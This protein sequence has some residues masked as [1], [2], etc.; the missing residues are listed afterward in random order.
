MA[1]PQKTLLD[2]PEWATFR[3]RFA[4]SLNDFSIAV[5][6]RLPTPQQE[7]LFHSVELSGS[8]TSVSSGHGCFGEGMEIPL[9]DGTIKRVEAISVGDRLLGLDGATPEVK[10]LA[11]GYEAMYRFT[12]A[13]GSSHTFNESHNIVL[14]D[15]GELITGTVRDFLCGIEQGDCCQFVDGEYQSLEIVSIESLGEGAYYG[16]ELDGN[17]L[18]FDRNGIVLSNTGKTGA[19]GVIVL[20]HLLCYPMS[21]TIVTAPRIAQVKNLAW[22]E[23]V[24][25]KRAM[26]ETQFSWLADEIVVESERIYI[27]GFKEGWY[28]I[29]KT[30]P[31]GNPENLA[32][33]HRNH[34]LWIVD[35]ASG[36]ED[37]HYAV[38]TGALTDSRN[39]MLLT[40]QPTRPSGF[41]YDTHHKLARKNGGVWT[42]LTFDSEKSLKPLGLV[43]PEFIA[44]K[45]LQYTETEYQIKVKGRFPDKTDG[46]LIGRSE[47]EKAFR[48]SC[49]KAEEEWGWMT[50]IDVGGGDYR[51][52]SV[53]LR[54][55]VIGDGDYGENARRIHIHSV[56]I[57][58][59]DMDEIQFSGAVFNYLIEQRLI[60]ETCMLD[61]GS[62]G[63]AV[64][65]ILEEKGT[66]AL[67]RVLWG[68][69]CWKTENKERFSNLRAQANAYA[70]RAVREGRLTFDS[71]I[72]GRI[73]NQILDEASRI[74]F[75]YDEKARYVIEKKEDMRK[76]GIPSPDIW[77]AVCFLFLEGAYYAVSYAD[78]AEGGGDIE[79]FNR[80]AD[81]YF[82]SIPD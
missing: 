18:F 45:R 42:A 54:A 71:S 47:I 33:E 35:E 43:S 48:E 77:D 36:V 25:L 30:A 40:S 14:V 46:F 31:R 8:R 13:D 17:H 23:I 66:N 5:C 27:R 7:A 1:K 39:R 10:S 50:S 79:S 20:W 6:K 56:P 44:E 9:H 15:S 80:A 60:N 38:M 34:L 12:Y 73:R 65:K 37:P 70:A 57:W 28:V 82:D 3:N 63:R 68:N 51:D 75:H 16:F 24:D 64:A 72:P 29:A 69:F 4:Y 53:L 67:I 76:K 61:A 59:N 2:I 22:K 21:N 62:S 19:I 52:K 41:F 55:M 26:E 49:V 32:G 81:D 58:A 11:R 74:P 78:A